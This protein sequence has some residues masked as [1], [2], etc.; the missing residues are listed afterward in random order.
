MGRDA[1]RSQIDRPQRGGRRDERGDRERAI[2]AEPVRGLAE[3]AGAGRA[4]RSRTASRGWAATAPRER[5]GAAR[6]DRVAREAELVERR[7][8]RDAGAIAIAPSSASRLA[9]TCSVRSVGV[10]ASASASAAAA[11]PLGRVA[12]E[13]D[14]LDARRGEPRASATAA[15]PSSSSS[16]LWRSSTRSGAPPAISAAIRR[17]PATPSGLRLSHSASTELRAIAPP[18]AASPASSMRLQPR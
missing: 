4:P 1:V 9:A 18:S 10:A 11:R 17:A 12:A 7:V 16:Q 2:V 6:A 14:V 5:P 3:R 8:A 15:T 13:V